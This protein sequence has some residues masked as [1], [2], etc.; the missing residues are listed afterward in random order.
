MQEFAM[1]PVTLLILLAIVAGAVLA[2][3]RLA[4][5]GLCDCGDHCD[6]GCRGCQ[7]CHEGGEGAGAGSCPAAEAVVARAQQGASR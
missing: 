3:R 7:G 5:R 2:V 6:G 4:H 1:N